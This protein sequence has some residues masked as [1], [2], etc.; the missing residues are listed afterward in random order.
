MRPR[1]LTA[2]VP[3]LLLAACVGAP[4]EERSEI[5]DDELVGTC[6]AAPPVTP[7]ASCGSF[8]FRLPWKARVKR[9]VTQGQSTAG[10]HAAGTKDAYAFDFR[11]RRC[12]GDSAT[13]LTADELEVRAVAGG[14]VVD[15]RFDRNE[16]SGVANVNFVLVEHTLASGAKIQSLYAHLKK[17]TVAPVKVGDRVARGARLGR[18]GASGTDAIHLHFQFQN[19]PSSKPRDCG[20]DY[21]FC[22]SV[23]YLTLNPCG[24][25]DAKTLRSGYDYA[26]TNDP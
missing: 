8:A 5:A 26:S 9:R 1:H 11:A 19:A 16:V 13:P 3:S 17:E 10:T 23:S 25:E 12:D 7:P 2:L 4:L 15:A 22:R 18:I 6:F 14:N 20:T 24:F 21:P